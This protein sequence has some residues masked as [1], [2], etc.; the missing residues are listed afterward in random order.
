M[1][2]GIVSSDL[3]D[4]PGEIVVEWKSTR[5][6]SREERCS[7]GKLQFGTVIGGYY[8]PDCFP[9]VQICDNES[10]QSTLC[11]EI[12]E[13]IKKGARLFQKA[14]EEGDLESAQ[15]LYSKDKLVV[16]ARNADGRAALHFACLRGNKE[17][18]KWLLDELKMDIEKADEAGSRAIHHAAK[19]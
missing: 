12:D 10:H 19:A 9:Y 8:H 5:E 4:K 7:R 3:A 14:V 16:D 15:F 6:K 2:I 17:M 18:V 1:E 11:K 13:W